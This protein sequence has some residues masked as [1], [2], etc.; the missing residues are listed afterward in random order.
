MRSLLFPHWGMV[1]AVAALAAC[2]TDSRQQILAT[3]NS[4]VALRAV[5]TRAFDTTE[6]N[7]MIRTVIATLQDLGFV[8]DQADEELGSVSATRLDGTAMRISVTVRPRGETQTAVRA[9]A[10]YGL[11]AVSD[12]RPYQQFFNA[13]EQAMF[14]TAHEVD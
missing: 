9:S 7:K 6:R 13:L 2:Q 14:L 5:Q 12:G 8:I 4:P 1:L 11:E 10:Q 3:P